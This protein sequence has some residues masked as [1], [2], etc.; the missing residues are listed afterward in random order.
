MSSIKVNLVLLLGSLFSFAPVSVAQDS[1]TIKREE[2]VKQQLRDRGINDFAT[3]TAMLNVPRHE[4]VPD[5]IKPYA[6]NDNALPIGHD[7]TISQP[8]IVAFMTQSLRLKRSDRVLEIGTGSGYQ[9]A[10]LA[11]IVDT[12]YTIEIVDALA[13]EAKNKLQELGYSKVMV[14]S[15]DG[16]LGWPEAA[17]F[18][19]IMVTA[20]AERV[21]QPLVDQLKEGGR[22]IIPIGPHHAVRQLKLL[23]KKKHKI[24]TKDLMP[25]RFVPFTRIQDQEPDP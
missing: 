22:I 12:V 16:Y 17:P 2:M 25:V 9:A 4:F 8:F 1:Y 3:L 7:Q 6:Y 5:D 11:K 13:Q 15:G 14:R 19:A 20:G 18:D 24:I 21:P 10:V 23:T